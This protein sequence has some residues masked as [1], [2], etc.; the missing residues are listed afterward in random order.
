MSRHQDKW[1]HVLRFWC[2]CWCLCLPVPGFLQFLHVVVFADGVL[3]PPAPLIIVVL[4]LVYTLNS[5]LRFSFTCSSPGYSFS[6]MFDYKTLCL[7][8]FSN[9][10]CLQ[11]NKKDMGQGP[12]GR[13]TKI[14]C[15][16]SILCCARE[17]NLGN[18]S[19][20]LVLLAYKNYTSCNMLKIA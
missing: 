15:F 3:F 8:V 4:L 11:K 13:W 1:K 20:F 10:L 19:V 7:E 5:F 12:A 2:I 9:Y 14:S 18:Y 6:F 17:S 16:P